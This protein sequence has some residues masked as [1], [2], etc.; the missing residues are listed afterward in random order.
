MSRKIGLVVACGLAATAASAQTDA[1]RA[2]SAEINADASA[3]TSYQ[4]GSEGFALA[5]S[6]GNS[7]LNIGG[8]VSFRTNLIFG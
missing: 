7:T 6:T 4:G 2:L 3:R 8:L 5:S 1:S